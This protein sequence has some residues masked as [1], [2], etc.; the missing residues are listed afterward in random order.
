MSLGT[1]Q[2]HHKSKGPFSVESH[3]FQLYANNHHKD[4]LEEHRDEGN[5]L[6]PVSGVGERTLLAM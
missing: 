5:E 1:S 6:D 2:T 4:S 3:H